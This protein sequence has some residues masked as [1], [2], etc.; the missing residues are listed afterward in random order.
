MKYFLWTDHIKR[1][2]YMA[3]VVISLQVFSDV[4]KRRKVFRVLCSTG[5]VTDFMFS[6]NVLFKKKIQSI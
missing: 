6:N 5:N 2:E 1:S 4:R 3:V